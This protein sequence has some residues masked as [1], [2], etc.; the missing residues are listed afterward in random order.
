MCGKTCDLVYFELI[1]LPSPIA[2]VL[3][4]GLKFFHI[5]NIFH[6]LSGRL[7]S[8]HELPCHAEYVTA[9]CAYRPSLL[10]NKQLG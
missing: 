1:E 2:P 8:K 5:Y 6:T 10:P 3:F 4:N 7:L 9:L